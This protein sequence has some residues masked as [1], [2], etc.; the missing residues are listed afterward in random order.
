MSNEQDEKDTQVGQ[1]ARSVTMTLPMAVMTGAALVFGGGGA[2]SLVTRGQ[3]E[4]AIEASEARIVAKLELVSKDVESR[5]RDNERLE[6]AQAAALA[7]V[8]T[9]IERVHKLEVDAAGTRP[10]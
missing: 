6:R 8:R 10:R 3:V 4:Q 5:G 7:E 1:P 9:L 2:G